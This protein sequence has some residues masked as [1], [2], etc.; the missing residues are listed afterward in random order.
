MQNAQCSAPLED[1][2][3]ETAQ[4]GAEPCMPRVSAP[5]SPTL[6]TAR[7]ARRSPPCWVTNRDASMSGCDPPLGCRYAGRRAQA[8]A[9]GHAQKKRH[10]ALP[11][12]PL[13]SQ[14]WGAQAGRIRDEGT[15]RYDDRN[16][17]VP[18][19][20]AGAASGTIVHA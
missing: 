19:R 4:W 9:A 13:L 7:P 15:R 18:Q 2:K 11:L 5:S 12:A 17:G 8:R 16:A 1:C 10:A 3:K 20:T 6:A 14:P